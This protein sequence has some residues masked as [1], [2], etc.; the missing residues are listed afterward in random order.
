M[1]AVC[2]IEGA[3]KINREGMSSSAGAQ[4][5][6]GTRGENSM[7]SNL[8]LNSTDIKPLF[9]YWYKKK[10]SPKLL[11]NSLGHRMMIGL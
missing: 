10:L 8:V 4:F 3:S 6:G 1:V 5:G 2:W 9:L 7:V 11:R